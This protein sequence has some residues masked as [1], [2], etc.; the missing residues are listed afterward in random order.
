[1]S[2]ETTGF[3]DLTAAFTA[4]AVEAENLSTT[5]KLFVART[6][7]R[8]CFCPDVTSPDCTVYVAA[9]PPVSIVAHPLGSVFVAEA[10]AESQR[11]HW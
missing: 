6:R 2:P 10:E 4:A 8:R 11:Y 9:V 1:L 7:T 3:V 5:P